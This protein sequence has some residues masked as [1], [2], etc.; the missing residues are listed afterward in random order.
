MLIVVLYVDDLLLFGDDT[1]Q[2][3]QLKRALKKQYKM[4]DLGPVQRFLGL[5]ITRGQSTLTRKSTSSPFSSVF[6]W[7]TVSRRVPLSLLVLF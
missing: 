1:S 3:T 5:C 7:L 4:T 2:I 6:T